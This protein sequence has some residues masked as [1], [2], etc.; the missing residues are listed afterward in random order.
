MTHSF[1]VC[2]MW[3]SLGTLLVITCS[4]CG[5]AVTTKG[6]L[7]RHTGDTNV[8][9]ITCTLCG[10]AVTTKGKLQRQTGD[11]GIQVY[12]TQQGYS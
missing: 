1:L 6:E 11:T 4:L 9:A 8:L 5:Y 10:Y 2:H 12:D 3:H 7:E